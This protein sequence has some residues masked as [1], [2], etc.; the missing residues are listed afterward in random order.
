MAQVLKY[1]FLDMQVCVPGD[2]TDEQV[3]DFAQTKFPCG[4]EHGWAVRKE[5]SKY[6]AGDKERTPCQGG[7]VGYVHITLDA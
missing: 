2:W 3:V 5:G 7:L 6:L 1:G 4:T